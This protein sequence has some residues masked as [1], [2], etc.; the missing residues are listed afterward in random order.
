VNELKRIG[1]Q[2]SSAA[3]LILDSWKASDKDAVRILKTVCENF[4]HIPVFVMQTM[5]GQNPISPV[6]DETVGRTFCVLHLWSLSREHIRSVVA[7]Y[8]DERHIGDEDTVTARVVND[9]D[10]LNIHRTPLNCLT[11]LKASE[12]DF[13]E[14]PV[15]RTEIL[16]RVL[17]ILFNIDAIPRYKSRPDM[18]DCEHVLGSFVENL[19]RNDEYTFTRKRFLDAVRMFCKEQVIA[20]DADV[21]FDILHNAHILVPFGSEFC[22][23]FTSWLYYFAAHRMHHDRGFADFILSDMHYSRFPEVMEFYTGIDRQREDAVCVLA[24]DVR[25]GVAK[26]REKCGLPTELNP[27]PLLEWHTTPENLEKMHSELR[28]GVAESNLPPLIKD[29][30]AD[31]N[32]DR[33]RPYTQSIRDILSGHSM[34]SLML[35]ISAAARALRNSDYVNPAERQNLLSAIMEGWRQVSQVLFVLLPPLVERGHAAFDGAWFVLIGDFGNDPVERLHRVLTVIPDNV[36]QWYQ[37]DLYSPKMAPLLSNMLAYESD[38][39]IKHEMILL[40]IAK[41]PIGWKENLQKYIHSNHK[42]S[43]YLSDVDSKLREQY[44]YAFASTRELKDLEYLI[45]MVTTKHIHGVKKPKTKAV[46]KM[47]DSVLP[48][49]IDQSDFD[50]E[51]GKFSRRKKPRCATKCKIAGI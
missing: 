16:H 10:T 22:F 23:K 13:D 21:L 35:S 38:A 34:A 6:D 26:V 48:E 28:E 51:Q 1:Q 14:N 11:V 27:L 32:Y 43:F 49:R 33:S 50:I 40:Q 45:K 41:R 8:N 39:L 30:Y 20:V 24:Q 42:R 2:E 4:S 44:S 12:A 3:C 5:D 15:N 18:K 9:I 29:R 7:G 47:S 25:S 46:G 36:V 37:D 19:I 31:R 17:F